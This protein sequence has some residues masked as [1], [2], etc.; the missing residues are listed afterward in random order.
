VAKKVQ[1]MIL[2]KRYNKGIK[3][4]VMPKNKRYLIGYNTSLN[5]KKLKS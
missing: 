2:L 5:I 1:R 4:G 3:R